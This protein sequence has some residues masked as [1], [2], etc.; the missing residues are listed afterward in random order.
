MFELNEESKKNINQFYQSQ[1]MTITDLYRAKNYADLIE[2]N[3][4]RLNYY[5]E[6]H[7]KIRPQNAQE[8]ARSL[9]NISIQ[10]NMLKAAQQAMNDG[11]F[12]IK[13]SG[14]IQQKISGKLLYYRKEL[15]NLFSKVEKIIKTPWPPYSF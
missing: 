7:R 1:R 9:N 8:Y 10:A 11:I 12:K 6:E 13:E 3:I 5:L 2:K 4:E 15:S 14:D